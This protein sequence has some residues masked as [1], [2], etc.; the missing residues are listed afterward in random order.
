MDDLW[1][2]N[3]VIGEWMDAYDEG[4]ANVS[5]PE[6]IETQA[7]LWRLGT[8][9][10][11]IKNPLPD[12]PFIDTSGFL[13]TPEQLQEFF[14]DYWYNIFDNS[15]I[16]GP[17]DIQGLWDA[18]FNITPGRRSRAPTCRTRPARGRWSIQLLWHP[19]VLS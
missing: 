3:P 15:G 5:N 18:I 6:M 9:L 19:T 11:D 7:W 2:G 10:L 17:F 14:G 8:V 12:D 16:I 4:T 1:P 13:P